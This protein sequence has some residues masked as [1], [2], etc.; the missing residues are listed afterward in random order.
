MNFSSS[1]LRLDMV[2]VSFEL[3]FHSLF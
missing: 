1:C 2:Y 3:Q